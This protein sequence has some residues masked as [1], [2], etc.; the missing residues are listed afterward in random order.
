[1]TINLFL[2]VL[3]RLSVEEDLRTTGLRYVDLKRCEG[4]DDDRK[5]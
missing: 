3:A 4:G 5:D 1:V 2:P